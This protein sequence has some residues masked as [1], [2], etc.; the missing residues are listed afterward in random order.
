MNKEEL[1]TAANVQLFKKQGEYDT[2][3]PQLQATDYGVKNLE[4]DDELVR[5]KPIIR[6]LLSSIEASYKFRD[7]YKEKS[8]N[9]RRYN[10]TAQEK[11]ALLRF[12]ANA[13][14]DKDIEE[15]KEELRQE[16]EEE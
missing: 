12:V 7:R 8:A 10:H 15:L 2:R 5:R 14:R 13:D 16:V 3:V 11:E 9:W 6:K 4:K 1:P